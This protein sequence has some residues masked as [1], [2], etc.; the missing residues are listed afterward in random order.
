MGANVVPIA[1]LQEQLREDG[2]VVL[3]DFFDQSTCQALIERCEALW[4]L[5]GD[6]AGSEFRAEPGT[7]RLANLVDKGEIFKSVWANP[8]VLALVGEVLGPDFKL[9]SLNAR[10]ANPQSSTSQPLHADMGAI[11][12]EKGFWVCN[13]VWL[14]DDFTPDNGALR[15]VPGT[16]KL[17]RLPQSELANPADTHPKEVL[18]TAPRGTVVVMNAHL[19]HGGT[20]NRT[21][22]PRRALHSFYCRRDKPQQQWQSK[23][24]GPET[25]AHLTSDERRL[26]ALHDE[27][28]DGLCA[29]GA[30]A[31]GFLK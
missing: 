16:H 14:L 20:A 3:P 11:H 5:E 21:D 23:L 28:N 24:L 4:A 6:Q 18:I 17:G 26:L 9:S 1:G 15:A 2:Y 22:R 31:S 10:S 29:A 7:R 25:V 12:D 13:T 19:W 8:E 30:G 27:E